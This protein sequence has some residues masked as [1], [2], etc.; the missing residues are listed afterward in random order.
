MSRP[1]FGR[2]YFAHHHATSSR[3]AAPVEA[4][5]QIGVERKVSDSSVGLAQAGGW[6][7]AWNDLRLEDLGRPGK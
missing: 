2:A 5:G 6:W 3:A 4:A 1:G 7:L